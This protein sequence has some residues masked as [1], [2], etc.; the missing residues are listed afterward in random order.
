MSLYR[1]HLSNKGS[2]SWL[3]ACYKHKK[4]H[5]LWE[6]VCVNHSHQENISAYFPKVVSGHVKYVCIK[7]ICIVIINYS[8]R[9][10]AL[11]TH[12][13]GLLSPKY[14]A[15]MACLQL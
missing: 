7:Y 8:D 14:E 5:M 12:T 4:G 13:L 15:I 9:R 2:I 3:Q 1:G 6:K 10:T 11:L